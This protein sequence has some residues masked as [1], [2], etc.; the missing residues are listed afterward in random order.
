MKI[1]INKKTLLNTLETCAKALNPHSALTSLQGIMIVVLENQIIFTTSNSNLSIKEII[2]KNDGLEIIEPG[3]ALIP[4]KLF[5]DIIKKQDEEITIFKEKESVII[6][7]LDSKV[8]INLLD[9]N[10]YPIISF[11]NYGEEFII[12]AEELKKI[13]SEVAFA[14]S[15][16]DKRIILNGVNLSLQNKILTI[17]ATNSF[18]LACKEIEVESNIE[19][20][21]SI[22]SKNLRHFIP[23][24]VK[25][26]IKLWV[27]D[28]KIVTQFK[29]TTIVSKLIDGIY[30]EIKRLIPNNFETE[31]IVN[32]KILSN[33]LDKAMVM[34]SESNVVVKLTIDEDVLALESKRDQIGDL[35]AKTNS[36]SKTGA[37]IEIAFNG[38]FLKEAISRFSGE[39][40]IGFNGPQKPFIIKSSSN[41]L[42]IQ[43][44]LPHRSY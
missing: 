31:V 24:N 28:A 23:T 38:Q 6:E 27:T 14:A 2:E 43:L 10:E 36:F 21:I 9:V 19:F 44:V 17:G 4:G 25:N 16:G 12:N 8:H 22:L 42:L 11:D 29:N 5:I 37:K 13:I 3:K 20:N 1:K 30:P 35:F 18:R 39:V 40:K 41:K 15:D 34:T 32:T 26:D 7:S 33:L